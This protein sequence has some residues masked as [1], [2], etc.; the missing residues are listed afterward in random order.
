MTMEGQ[1]DKLTAD[2]KKLTQ[3]LS[4]KEVIFI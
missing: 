3:T 2:N 1:M 4:E